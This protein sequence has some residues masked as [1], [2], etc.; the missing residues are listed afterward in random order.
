MQ[1]SQQKPE[2]TKILRSTLARKTGTAE[3]LHDLS[4]GDEMRLG[5]EIES[6]NFYIEQ[7]YNGLADKSLSELEREFGNR[8]EIASLEGSS[9]RRNEIRGSFRDRTAVGAIR[10]PFRSCS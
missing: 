7:G 6:I 4:A 3:S 1:R 10:L 9:R 8:P 5:E 2:S